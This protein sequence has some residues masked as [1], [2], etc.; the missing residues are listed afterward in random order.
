MARFLS[1]DW[2]T[3]L[4][5]AAG[6]VRLEGD[7]DVTVQQVVV[8]GAGDPVRW[9]VR[10][11]GDR[12]LVVAGGVADPDVTVTT[13]RATAAALARG[14]VAVTDAFM[15]GRIRIA[16]DLRAL[17]QAGGVLGALDTAFAAVRERTTWD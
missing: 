7:L 1:A 8:D 6:N 17:L 2:V 13:D 14:E 9:A 5:T 4:T 12:V 3:D 15:A 10:V 11:T 16:G